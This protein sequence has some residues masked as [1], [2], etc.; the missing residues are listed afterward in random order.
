MER[1]CIHTKDICNIVGYSERYART[2]LNKIL[3][4]HNKSKHQR[5]T[6]AEFSDYFGLDPNEVRKRLR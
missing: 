1:L 3:K 5:V 4:L 2:I 6:I